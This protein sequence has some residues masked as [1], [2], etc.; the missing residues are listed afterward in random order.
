MC[1]MV[2]LLSWYCHGTVMVLS[3]YCHGTVMVLS[4]YCHGTVMVLS[5]YCHGT[6]MVLSWSL[7]GLDHNNHNIENQRMKVDI[8]LLSHVWGKIDKNHQG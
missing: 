2:L 3:L 4:W 1:V 8:A 5:W 7:D 6:V